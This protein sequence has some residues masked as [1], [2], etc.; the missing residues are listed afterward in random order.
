[1]TRNTK[2]RHQVLK[3]VTVDTYQES[4]SY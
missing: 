1:M 3:K 4:S 2:R